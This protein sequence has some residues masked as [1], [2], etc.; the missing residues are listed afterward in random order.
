MLTLIIDKLRVGPEQLATDYVDLLKEFVSPQY[1]EMIAE[2]VNEINDQIIVPILQSNEGEILSTFKSKLLPF[3]IKFTGI[4]LVMLEIQKGDLL[5]V[6]QLEQMCYSKI[7]KWV[8]EASSQIG[9]EISAKITEVIERMADYENVL[10]G[11]LIKRPKHL[12]EAL[13][14]LD[15]DDL[16]TNIYSTTLAIACIVVILKESKPNSKKLE[17][18][19]RV[20]E[21]CS[22][23]MESYA[24]TLDIMSNKEEMELLKQCEQE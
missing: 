15:I 23:V 24:D 20:A 14:Q 2:L 16:L 12:T 10:L 1:L 13:E 4:N 6:A 11:I 7:L 17:I 21:E 18:L 3:I 19:L 9:S 22:E 8:E 5:K